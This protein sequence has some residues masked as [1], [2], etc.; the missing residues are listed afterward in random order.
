[1]KLEVFKKRQG[2]E[3]RAFVR[4]VLVKHDWRLTPAAGEL[5][6]ATT[7][8]LSAIKR[9]GLTVEYQHKNPGRGKR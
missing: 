5:G 2:I 4:T 1:M 8:L 3:E 9:L 6:I 7:S